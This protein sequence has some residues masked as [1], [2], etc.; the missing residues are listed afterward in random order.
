[1]GTSRRV[2]LSFLSV[3]VTAPSLI[4]LCSGSFPSP[5]LY[6]LYDSIAEKGGGGGLHLPP[7]FPP[8]HPLRAMR[9]QCHR[10]PP[11]Y[12]FLPPHLPVE[13]HG[14]VLF[15][16]PAHVRLDHVQEGP[17]VPVVLVQEG[18]NGPA[19]HR[20]G[21]LFRPFWPFSCS[22]GVFSFQFQGL[23]GMQPSVWGRR[24]CLRG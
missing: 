3:L 6:L 21:C 13:G 4:P 7:L 8:G 19:P 2:P 5:S 1:M 9:A 20:F 17:H 14:A 15:L 22:F 16:E 10:T 23:R 18:G 12:P 11:S 24:S